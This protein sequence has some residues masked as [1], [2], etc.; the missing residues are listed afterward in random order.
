M[1]MVKGMVMH[2]RDEV[3]VVCDQLGEEELTV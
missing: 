2:I 3:V 1:L